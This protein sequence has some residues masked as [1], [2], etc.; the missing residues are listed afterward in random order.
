LMPDVILANSTVNLTPVEQVTRTV[1]VVFV[2]VADPV[3]QGFVAS[4]RQPGGNL[5][6]F[7]MFEFSLGGKWL[8]LLKQVAPSLR[9][10]AVMFNPDTAP[11]SRFLMQ[12]IEAAAPSLGVQAIA[13]PVRAS[14]DIEPALASS[15]ASP[16]AG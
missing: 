15:R 9:R 11:Y 6:G 3:G 4:V 1:P 14:A 5:T 13:V 12:T 8:D 10:V 7:S 2:G 16:T